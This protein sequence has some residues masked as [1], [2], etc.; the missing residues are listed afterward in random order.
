MHAQTRL[1]AHD[2]GKV[3]FYV[4]AVDKPAAKLSR[5]EFDE[6][7][8][9][10][11]VSTTGKLP[12]FLSFFECMEMILSESVLPPR[13]VRG[14]PCKV[15]GIEPHPQEHPIHSR[16]SIASDGCVV[17]YYLPKCI[18]VRVERSTD[19]VYNRVMLRS[20]PVWT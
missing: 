1:D 15:A 7:R 6:M 16:G 11:N 14:T 10:P 12:G 5:K 8:A 2:S 20:L 17:L 18:Y 19:F 3:L 9:F 13:Y 4:A